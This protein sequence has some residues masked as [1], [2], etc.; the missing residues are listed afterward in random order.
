M[1]QLVN[2]A[3][4]AALAV[5]ALTLTAARGQP[6]PV[7]E[8]NVT[9]G[10]C[11][12]VGSEFNLT[13][14]DGL[15]SRLLRFLRVPYA[16]PPVGDR[17]FAKP[18][19]FN[20]SRSDCRL[21]G[22]EA[23]DPE[24]NLLRLS[25][26]TPD[27]APADPL[28]VLA[29][30]LDGSSDF[31][32][33]LGH[34]V[35]D[36]IGT[37]VVMATI[38]SRFGVLGNVPA[39]QNNGLEDQRLALEFLRDQ[40][41]R[42]GGDPAR[43][44]LA[45]HGAAAAAVGLHAVGSGGFSRV[46]MMSGS[47]AAPLGWS[48]SAEVAAALDRQLAASLSCG[49]GDE[50]RLPLD[51]LRSKPLKDLL[52]AESLLRRDYGDGAGRFAP[53]FN[54]SSLP[55]ALWR[56]GAFNGSLMV[57]VG[58]G[59]GPALAELA[60]RVQGADWGALDQTAFETILDRE[61]GQFPR[62]HSAGR[63]ASVSGR[64]YLRLTLSDWPH[65][66]YGGRVRQILARALSDFGAVCPVWEA[67]NDM[68]GSGRVFVYLHDEDGDPAAT[69]SVANDAKVLL[70]EPLVRANYSAEHRSLSR[71]M[72]QHLVD[73]TASG[74]PSPGWPS[75]SAGAFDFLRF[76]AK[77][78]VNSTSGGF[79]FEPGRCP[80]WSAEMSLASNLSASPPPPQP[81]PPPPP[82]RI[83]PGGAQPFSNTVLRN[84]TVNILGLGRMVGQTIRTP[85]GKVMTQFLGLP[86]AK[87]PIGGKRFAVP[88]PAD[89][90]G[91]DFLA[92]S[93]KPACP[94]PGPLA[95]S[96][97]CLYLNLWTPMH[98]DRDVNNLPVLVFLHG[99]FFQTGDAFDERWRGS[100]V[101]DQ[102]DAMV[103]TVAYRLG[104]L[105]FLWLQNASVPANLGLRDQALALQWVRYNVRFFG[106]SPSKI[107]LVGA[108]AGAASVG[109]HLLTEPRQF[110]RAV[111][112]SGSPNSPFAVSPMPDE[113][114]AMHE[115]FTAS[116]LNCSQSAPAELLDCLRNLTSSE[117]V[118]AAADFQR[119][120][121]GLQA[122]FVAFGP[123]L[124]A[125]FLKSDPW[126]VDA[127]PPVPLLLG[128]VDFPGNT[129]V[130]LLLPDGLNVT[131]DRVLEHLGQSLRHFPRFGESLSSVGLEAASRRFAEFP[132]ST[133]DAGVGDVKEAQLLSRALG[134][135]HFTCPTWSFM[136]KAAALS[137][138]QVFG[139]LLAEPAEEI[140]DRLVGASLSDDAVY[141]LGS[142]AR[143]SKPLGEARAQLSGF[144]VRSLVEFANSGNVSWEAYG[145][146]SRR[147]LLLRDSGSGGWN[148]SWP[149]RYVEHALR[150]LDCAFWDQ[151]LP[152][153]ASP[154]CINDLPTPSPTTPTEAPTETPTAPQTATPQTEMT[155]STGTQT[156]NPDAGGLETWAVALILVF[157]VVG[158]GLLIGSGFLLYRCYFRSQ[159]DGENFPM[160][161]NSGR[162]NPP[163][164]QAGQ[165]P[166][167]QQQ[168]RQH[169]QPE[170]YLRQSRPTEAGNSNGGY[171]G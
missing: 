38:G 7:G 94:Q 122:P 124:D 169:E 109:F 92:I 42:F 28:P 133:A 62:L 137:T 93:P 90:F 18:Q 88:E 162:A 84:Y 71:I 115:N 15:G 118:S 97:D 89:A 123:A 69:L 33:S 26:R 67:A 165:Q 34:E 171:T 1:P 112:L 74:A 100:H 121:A 23:A 154:D 155:D 117:I 72:M 79:A 126:S 46:V 136:A 134:D 44:T 163:K 58:T 107:S 127:L 104:A 156:P 35:G 130:R 142:P 51:C 49:I 8:A 140:G 30:L 125:D 83:S 167:P 45:G 152:C 73:F 157:S 61:F 6:Q 76:G 65:F 55:D 64:R 82:A 19:P 17:R 101:L 50:G 2:P 103:V 91:E 85:A 32:D 138:A 70:G 159:S 57:G 12:I 150:G 116:Y 78:G 56:S 161:S 168:Y 80:L 148:V 81:P 41:H 95:T 144:L 128:G 9:I 108:E 29:L 170:N 132:S 39:G 131:R 102:V 146:G 40:L 129:L 141:A 158:A 113:V 120:V 47:I 111:L 10:S 164:R 16:E 3:A 13:M 63:N 149:P 22:E 139:F 54:A 153:V 86:Y 27:L 135:R 25:I 20:F 66:A 119:D 143:P 145:A 4:I 147:V 48:A 110:Q 160:E 106:G 21:T 53:S 11:S 98:S 36:A 60:L 68:I 14:P 24:E 166:P 52:D 43:V 105:G 114:R 99:G 37:N 59:V 31:N 87:P 75:S 77:T 151:T 5:V 96:E